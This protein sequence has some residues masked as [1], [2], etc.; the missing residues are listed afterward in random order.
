MLAAVLIVLLHASCPPML[1]KVWF[2]RTCR[3]AGISHRQVKTLIQL[4]VLSTCVANAILIS[5]RC[6]MEV[7]GTHISAIPLARAC[8]HDQRCLHSTGYAEVAM[9][10]CVDRS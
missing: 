2:V 7:L 6:Q 1:V 8:A 10:C 4:P 3:L 9:A 5:D